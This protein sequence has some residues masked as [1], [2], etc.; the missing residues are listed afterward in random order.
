MT[1]KQNINIMEN[2]LTDLTTIEKQKRI[3]KEF[4][5]HLNKKNDSR[6]SDCSHT[7]N[8]SLVNLDN[9]L[10]NISL[11]SEYLQ[12]AENNLVSRKA[13]ID[14]KL[15]KKLNIVND[16]QN[17]FYLS[18]K[19]KT[20]D[21]LYSNINLNVLKNKRFPTLK[22]I[23]PLNFINLQKKKESLKKNILVQFNKKEIKNAIILKSV[24][25]G[26]KIFCNG[27]IGFMSKSQVL[28][29]I[30]NKISYNNMIL[31]K[32]EL[33]INTS[34]V[35]NCSLNMHFQNIKQNFS[36]SRKRRFNSIET[37]FL[38]NNKKHEKN[39]KNIKTKSNKRHRI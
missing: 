4:L 27:L 26:F 21:T 25:G 1:N 8:I 20:T 28:K 19:R 39:R 32:N 33:T 5:D 31:S 3:D 23:A 16:Y 34:T 2:H 37:S 18:E 15:N 7:S 11:K 14:A 10:A 6:N 35:Q 9:N 36:N 13:I 38:F 22:L 30:K 12:A 24:R 29:G 17:F